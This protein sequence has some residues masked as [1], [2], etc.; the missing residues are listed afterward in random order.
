VETWWVGDWWVGG[1]GR[2]ILELLYY[3]SGDL[4]GG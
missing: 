1:G 3:L 4:V 2:L